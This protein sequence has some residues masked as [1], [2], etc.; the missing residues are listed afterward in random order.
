MR[1]IAIAVIAVVGVVAVVAVGALV[2]VPLLGG[3]HLVFPPGKGKNRVDVTL[4]MQGGRC[5]ALDPSRLGERDGKQITWHVVNQNCQTPQYV[6]FREYREDLGGGNYG[7]P[8]HVVDKDP[9]SSPQAIP[10][11]ASYDVT[12]KIDKA[13]RT[14]IFD[15]SYKY[16]IC[17]E[18]TPDPSTN[19]TDPDVDVWPF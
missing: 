13:N 6:S 9:A 5:I 8:E 15:L 4:S 10:M 18:P 17:I 7:M 3:P 19:C 1:R 2:V 16:K 14:L 12:A 11:L